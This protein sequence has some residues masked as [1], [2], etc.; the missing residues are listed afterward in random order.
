[1]RLSL[2]R[3]AA[4][5]QWLIIFAAWT[6]LAVFSSAQSAVYFIQ[7]DQPIDWG[8]ML[9]YRFADW[10]TCALF[11][12]LFFWLARRYPI[13]GRRWRTAL[14]LTLAVTSV[15]VVLKYALLVPIERSMGLANITVASALSR[16]FASESM[17]FW[18]VVGIIHAFE[19]NRRYRER[20]IAAAD[21]RTK[22]SE[23]Q[24]EA[25]RS[26]IHP[27]FLFNT[28]HSISTLMHRDVEAADSMLTRL[29]DLLRLT[30]KHR[31]ENEIA[32]RDELSLAD[33]YLAIMSIRFG[34]RLTIAQTIDP[35]TLEA[36]VPQFV[37]QPLLEN[38][39][40][41]GV[42]TTPGPARVE[43]SARVANGRLVLA[44]TDNG[45]GS[46]SSSRGERHGMGLSNTRLRLEQLY[47][48]DHSLTL[49]KLPE[50]GTRI[51]VEM[52]LRRAAKPAVVPTPSV[53]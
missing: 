21:L 20:E 18:A 3:R 16:N 22:L 27:H 37:L 1:M 35:D 49:E 7:R 23:A 4:L 26:Q 45:R 6:F 11:T 52:P 29:S 2:E 36:L 38:A 40:Q 13:D 5:Q 48:R 12:P 8:E 30:L 32:L 41:H 19:F 42:A 17:A 43:I 31:G 25:L 47:G 24:L 33:H 51:S 28:L 50:R 39:L 10:Y 44:V 34:D 46:V 53:A 9:S 15:C 14:P